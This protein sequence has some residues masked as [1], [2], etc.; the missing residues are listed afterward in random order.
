MA[1]LSALV[2]ASLVLPGLSESEYSIPKYYTS[3]DNEAINIGPLTTVFTP[4]PS[5]TSVR[6]RNDHGYLQYEAGCEGPGG[7]ECCPDGWR[8][9]VYYSPGRCPSGYR[10]YSLLTTAPRAETTNYC[11]PE[12]YDL[13]G[14]SACTKPL[15]TR[16]TL[17][18]VEATTTY[19]NAAYGITATPIQIRFKAV[20]SSVVPIPSHPIVIP[21]YY[22]VRDGGKNDDS[23]SLP[24]AAKVGIAFAAA[25]GFFTLVYFCCC[26]CRPRKAAVAEEHQELVASDPPP[27]YPGSPTVESSQGPSPSRK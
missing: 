21:D 27:A 15:N 23:N 24:T 2:F 25:A 11:C 7:D 13:R 4:A 14:R 10:A 6:F 18:L 22:K 17:S 1:I 5:C 16:E 12:G 9:G 8:S 3:L 19:T 20:D 26:C